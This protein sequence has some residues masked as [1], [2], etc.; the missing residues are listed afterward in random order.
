MIRK[1][2]NSLCLF[3]FLFFC[4]QSVFALTPPT[5]DRTLCYVEGEVLSHQKEEASDML[6]NKLEVDTIT[7]I[8][9]EV[10]PVDKNYGDRFCEEMAGAEQ[11][12]EQKINTFRLCDETD[13]EKGETIKGIVGKSLGGGRYCIEKI[14]LLNN[15]EEQSE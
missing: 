13:A 3:L 9:H 15:E 5:K 10:F 2:C 1:Y 14:Q 8:I 7:L 11:Q 4:S 12:T 6:M